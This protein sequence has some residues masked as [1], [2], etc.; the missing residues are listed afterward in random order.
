MNEQQ[1]E[2]RVKELNEQ[3]RK[4]ESRIDQLEKRLPDT[5]LMSHSQLKR[6]ATVVLYLAC[7]GIITLILSIP[8]GLVLGSFKNQ[9]LAHPTTV[10]YINV[11]VSL[12]VALFISAR[13]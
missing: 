1:A 5:G 9:F 6:I 7:W 12:L 13:R 3:I 11:G 2:W 8:V 4:L 10:Q